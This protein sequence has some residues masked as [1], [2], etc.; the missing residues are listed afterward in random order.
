MEATADAAPAAIPSTWHLTDRPPV[1]RRYDAVLAALFDARLPPPV[2]PAR[3][4]RFL[5]ERER[6]LLS[7][8][9]AMSRCWP[10]TLRYEQALRGRTF[11]EGTAAEIPSLID[12]A[13]TMAEAIDAAALRW[14]GRSR[15]Q[16]PRELF[17]FEQSLR[18]PCSLEPATATRAER[19]RLK[20]LG[21]VDAQVLD[22]AIDVVAL[23]QALEFLERHAAA[24]AQY[25]SIVPAARPTRLGFGRHGA[26]RMLVVL[27]A[28]R[29]RRP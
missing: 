23:A 12:T 20:S 28:P 3:Q 22:F 11:V 18:S 14:Q 25:A 4:A 19:A 1:E 5:A 27:R 29:R 17:R 10:L 7:V 21:L 15:E 8:G 16:V 24:A 6:R 2:A 9:R 26:R 13:T